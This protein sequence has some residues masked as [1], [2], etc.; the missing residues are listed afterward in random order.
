MPGESFRFIHASDFHLERPLG[1]LDELPKHLNDAIAEAP[2]KAAEAVFEAAL[3]ENVDF[4]LLC[5]DLLA[6]Q[7]AGPRGMSMLIDAFDAL[8]ER[9]I[10]V[11][12]AAGN[13]DAAQSWPESIPLPDNV[14]RL[15]KA[16][17]E[18]VPIVR[19]GQTIALV[20]GRSSDSLAAVHTP[21]YRIDPTD[22]FT[23]G[24]AY[25]TAEGATLAETRFDYWAL[26]GS[27]QRRVMEEGAQYGAVF[28]GS[29]QARRLDETGAH[30]FHMVDVDAD[31]AARLHA[32]DADVFRYC[33]VSLDAG[34]LARGENLRQLL[35]HRISRLLAE[36]GERHLLIGWELHPASAEA[37]VGVGDPTE[38][39]TW[40]RREFGN[41]NPSAWSLSLDINPPQKYPKP[42]QE[43]DTI[44]GDFLRAAERHRKHHGRD[45]NMLPM[46]EEHDGLN[47]VTASLLADADPSQRTR[48][49]GDATLLGVDLLR[50]GK[51]KL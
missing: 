4:V 34:D 20:V 9:E 42:W 49:L 15:P 35:A 21:S 11:I 28:C 43:E 10:K 33:K 7:A 8:A 37:L 50:G 38:L 22:E 27:H 3:I 45:L 23:I 47:T 1:D 39:L 2:W 44:L 17:T 36:N 6:P 16:R 29:P 13:V 5:G 40:L 14:V 41:G 19:S 31:G 12:W 46:T 30:G 32:V 48:I 26:G 24:V 18:T 51:T 25:G